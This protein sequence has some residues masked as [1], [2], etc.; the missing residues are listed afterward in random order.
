MFIEGEKGEEGPIG[1][2]GVKGDKGAVG[3]TGVKGDPGPRGDIGD[4]GPRGLIGRYIHT[5]VWYN[6]YNNY[7]KIII[8]D[9]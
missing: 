4:R 3:P 7:D 9:I 5:C 2:Q 1:H 6:G 8:R